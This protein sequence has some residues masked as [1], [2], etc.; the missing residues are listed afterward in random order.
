M[1][2]VAYGLKDYLGL[3]TYTD[4]QITHHA[5]ILDY[6]TNGNLILYVI[7]EVATIDPNYIFEHGLTYETIE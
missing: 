6:K 4:F 2:I 7:Y 5:K 1:K 3:W